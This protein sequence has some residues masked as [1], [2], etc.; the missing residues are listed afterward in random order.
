MKRRL[1]L[2]P[3]AKLLFVAIII[4]AAWYAYKH[5]DKISESN[6]FNFKESTDTNNSAS[7]LKNQHSSDTIIFYISE[8]DTLI[9]LKVNNQKMIILK[10]TSGIIPDTVFFTVSKKKNSIGKLIGK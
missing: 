3:F 1:K 7:E 5:Q 6:F 8:N 4:F 10:D 9:N 2:T